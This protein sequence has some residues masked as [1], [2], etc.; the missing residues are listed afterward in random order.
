ML[1]GCVASECGADRKS[2]QIMLHPL[3]AIG[4]L[5]LSSQISYHMHTMLVG[6]CLQLLAMLVGICLQLLVA[7]IACGYKQLCHIY[8]ST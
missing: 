1:P 5:L 4:S 8:V 3:L 6:I 2:N 7:T